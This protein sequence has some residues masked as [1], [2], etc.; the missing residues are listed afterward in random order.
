MEK[1]YDPQTVEPKW[2]QRWLE[3]GAFHSDA[4]R[5]GTPY[6]VV[7]PPPNVTGILHMG[8]ALN[9][10]IQDILVRWRRMQGRNVVW[11]PGTDHAGI[12]T[13]NVVERALRQEGKSRQDL[14]RDAFVERVWAWKEQYGNTIIGQLKRMGASC[15]WERERFTMDAGLS[16]AVAEV[17][18]RLFDK[19]LIY[20]ANYIINW[21][22]RCQTALSDEESEHRDTQGQLYYIRYPLSPGPAL[23]DGR[24][25]VVVATTRPE[26][27]L[28]DVAVAVNPKDERYA[29]L[30]GR[31]LRL[32]ILGRELV[33]VCDDFVDREFGTGAVKVTPAHDP[34]D[35]E[36]GRRHGLA[37]INVMNPDGTLNAEAGPYAGLDRA[38]GRKRILTDL[39]AAGLLEKIVAHQHAVGHCYRCHTVVEPRLSPQWFVRMQP[40]AGPALE[41]VQSGRVKF[42]PARWNKVYTDWMV[43]IRDWCI[44]RQIWWGHRIPVFTCQSCEHVWAAKGQ[45]VSCPKCAKQE[46][47][48]DPDVLDTWFSSWLWPFSTFGW[49]NQTADLTYYY[50]SHD[51]AT[52]SEIIFFWVARMVM[53]GLEFM[54]DVPF[55]QVYIHGTVR[56]DRGQ[57]MSKSLGNS[58]DPLAIIERF[59]ADAL[60]F[61]LMMITATGQDVYVSDEKFEIGRNF[62][63]KLWNAARFM[64]MHGEVP[65]PGAATWQ[66]CGPAPWAG[67]TLSPDDQHLLAQLWAGIESCNASLEAYRFND[68]ALA[69]YEFIWHQYCDWYVEYAKDALYSDDQ[70]RKAPVIAIMHY[71]F[72]NALRLLHPMMPFVTEELWHA[73]GYGTETEFIM[74]SSWPVI[75]DNA[76]R[77]AAGV[78]VRWVAYVNDKHE[79]IRAGRTLKADYNLAAGKSVKFLI[80]PVDEQAAALLQGDMTSLASM[81][82]AE[83]LVIDPGLTPPRAAPSALSKLGTLYMPLEGLVDVEAERGRL[84]TQLTA[85]LQDLD[86]TSAKLA[87]QGFVSKAPPE[88]VERQQARRQELLENKDKL[89]RLLDTLAT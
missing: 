31:T 12:A 14:G 30:H 25:H 32:P 57:K 15:D 16:D 82:K 17:F 43:N 54:G 86:R 64:Q 61:S 60:R 49:P 27:L 4:T 52:A 73:M 10:T 8:H 76:G 11:M 65:P 44:S 84:N 40:L 81:L 33:V 89:T 20:R 53:A 70:A 1:H 58:I 66:G 38:E 36:L 28:G 83:S 24:D 55:R 45:P 18:V 88:V 51:L 23:S 47:V 26:T 59:S 62:A 46:I 78:D 68:A 5:G 21:C 87:N 19:G 6:C 80:K 56:D 50:P 22:P 42:T 48:Q 35:F 2:Y 75:P 39:K 41:A 3:A 13:Q 85:L 74:L 71:A 69:L 34:N 9:N 67:A 29:S 63:T 79:L 72:A 77:T 7:I 37:S